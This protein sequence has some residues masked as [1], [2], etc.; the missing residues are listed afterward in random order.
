LAKTTKGEINRLGEKIRKEYGNISDE[1]IQLL[2]NYRTS[3]KDSLAQIFR[4]LCRIKY[5]VGR[6]TIVTYRIKRFESIINK[7][8]R[9]PKMDFSRMWDIGGCRC[10]VNSN[11]EVYKLRD[12]INKILNIK[13]VNDWIENPQSDG[14]KSLHLYVT[15]PEDDNTFEIQIRNQNDHNWATLVEISDLL[16]DSELKEYGKNKDLLKFHQLLAKRKDLDLKE[17]KQIARISKKYKYIDKIAKVFVRNHLRVR[18]QWLDI[19]TKSRYKYFLIEASKSEVPKIKAYDN[20]EDAELDYFTRFKNN[21]KA[22]IVLT[23][24][25]K[26]SY[27]QISIAYSNYILTVHSFE[28]ESSSIFESLIIESLKKG[29]YFDFFS[30]FDYYQNIVV[31]R[32]TNSAK[33]LVYSR[34]L[35][36]NKSRELKRKMTKK[37]REWQE[38]IKKELQENYR[39]IESFQ[40]VFKDF[41]PKSGINRFIVKRMMKYVFWKQKR[42]LKKLATT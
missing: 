11:S 23:H 27:N 21:Q 33:E 30:F 10:I 17:K 19:E 18:E 22:N 31:N 1:T 25:P 40:K 13:K 34:T 38:D 5:K 3:H 9:F 42:R 24:L 36:E 16:F 14:Y 29:N 6:N 4:E 7:L 2:E 41:L 20:F 12:E 32:L 15:L 35:T 39:K 26:P 37:E 28:D 8:H